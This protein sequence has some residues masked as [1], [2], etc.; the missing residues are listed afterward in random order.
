MPKLTPSEAREKH[1]R[2]LKASIEDIRKGIDRVTVAPGQLAAAKQDKMQ[3]RL[4]EALSSGKWAR[5]VAATTLEDWKKAAREKG[6]NRIAGGIDAAA[7]KTEAFYSE[8]FPYE[9]SLQGKIKSMSDV[10]LEDNIGRAE[11][12]MRGM[13]QFRRSR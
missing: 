8:L 5:R 4:S 7:A 10:T 13:A 2:N 12:W 1:A 11:S 6:V 3:A 9:E